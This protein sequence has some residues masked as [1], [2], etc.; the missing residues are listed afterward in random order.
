[1][2]S[3]QYLGGDVCDLTGKARS[4]NVRYVCDAQAEQ[5]EVKSLLE[6]STCQ[7]LVVVAAPALCKHP[8]FGT[9]VRAACTAE[10]LPHADE[11]WCF[12]Y[13]VSGLFVRGMHGAPLTVS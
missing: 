7:Y 9:Q 3:D 6:T 1:M 11:V 8:L 5:L 13:L 2:L 12:A 4:A 10:L